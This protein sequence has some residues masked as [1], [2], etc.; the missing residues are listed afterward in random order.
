M[1]RTGT[2][3]AVARYMQQHLMYSGNG[4]GLRF[5]STERQDLGIGWCNQRTWKQ[6]LEGC[7]R[8]FAGMHALGEVEWSPTHLRTWHCC[9]QCCC[10]NFRQQLLVEQKF[11]TGGYNAKIRLA[12]QYH[13]HWRTSTCSA[14]IKMVAGHSVLQR[15]AQTDAGSQRDPGQ[16]CPGRH[17]FPTALALWSEFSGAALSNGLELDVISLNS[18]VMVSGQLSWESSLSMLHH[19]HAAS[20]SPDAITCNS[21]IQCCSEASSWSR[22]LVLTFEGEQSP[23]ISGF[24]AAINGL[25]SAHQWLKANPEVVMCVYTSPT[26]LFHLES[27]FTYCTWNLI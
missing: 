11:G 16:F 18:A 9:F 21:C 5:A 14:C 17:P 12:A 27:S 1:A 22:V 20:I 15:L 25:S 7:L 19:V 4:F 10:D 6:W 8:S 13:H 24:N 3:E 26:F 23:N 2:P